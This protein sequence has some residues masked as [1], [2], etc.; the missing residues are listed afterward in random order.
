MKRKLQN[1]NNSFFARE[2]KRNKINKYKGK[3]EREKNSITELHFKV[4]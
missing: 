2:R 4:N 3:R 1:K